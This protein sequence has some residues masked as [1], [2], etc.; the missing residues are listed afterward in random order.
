MRLPLA[1]AGALL[2]V[3]GPAAAADN[4]GYPAA[5]P[6]HQIAGFIELR[7]GFDSGSETG[8]Y[9]DGAPQ[10]WDESFDGG[11]FGG[12][13]RAAM[14]LGPNVSVQADVWTDVFFGSGSGTDTCCGPYSF[15]YTNTFSGIAGHLTWAPMGGNLLGVFASVGGVEDWG[16]FATFGF[17]GALNY[18]NWRAYGQVGFTSAIAGDADDESAD[19]WY[20]RAVL[21][22][23]MTPNAV[24]S[25]NLGYDSYSDATDGGTTDNTVSWGARLEFKP[26]SMPVSGFVAYQGWDWSGEDNDPTTWDGSEHAFVVGFRA[27]FN[28]QTLQEMDAVAGLADMNGLYGEAFVH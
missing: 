23:Y 26:A 5:A 12:T 10:S 18:G 21:A 28:A 11:V 20:T 15:D 3:L 25:A 27:L 7:G 22:Y 4:F 8:T 19:D 6:T 24:F 16:T 17:E 14:S 1:F 9:D 2:G 13:G